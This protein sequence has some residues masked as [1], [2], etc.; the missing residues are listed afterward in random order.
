MRAS[1]SIIWY[2]SF[3]SCLV[4][5]GIVGYIYILDLSIGIIKNLKQKNHSQMKEIER[6]GN[7]SN[8][9]LDALNILQ[10]MLIW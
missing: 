2:R 8:K 1:S 7:T 9:F 10:S 6:Y 3:I 4:S 5:N